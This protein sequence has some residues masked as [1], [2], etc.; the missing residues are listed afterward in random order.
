MYI[1]NKTIV[2]NAIFSKKVRSKT[3]STSYNGSSVEANQAECNYTDLEERS[4]PS[5]NYTELQTRNDDYSSTEASG[6]AYVNTQ[7]HG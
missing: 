7:M 5:S 3:K 4:R 2:T 1:H 6:H